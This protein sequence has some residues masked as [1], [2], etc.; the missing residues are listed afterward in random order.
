MGDEC[1]PALPCGLLCACTGCS[2]DVLMEAAGAGEANASCASPLLELLVLP[3][4]RLL[5][6]RLLLLSLPPAEVELP[7]IDRRELAL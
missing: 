4:L 7:T 2:A 3:L 1:N 5:L 6:S